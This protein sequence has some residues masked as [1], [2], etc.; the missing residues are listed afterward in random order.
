MLRNI[1]KIEK[2]ESCNL[3]KFISIPATWPT[4]ERITKLK[5]HTQKPKIKDTPDFNLEDLIKTNIPI[6]RNR[7]LLNVFIFRRCSP[8]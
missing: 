5:S 6:F 2:N 4:P 8:K 7:N 3:S 1:E